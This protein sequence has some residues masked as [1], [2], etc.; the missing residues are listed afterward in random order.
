M[1]S[2]ELEE[3]LARYFDGDLDDAAAARLGA[4]LDADPKTLD[5]FH[6]LAAI[7]GLLRAR[8]ADRDALVTRVTASVRDERRRRLTLRVMET[9]HHRA[10]RNRPSHAI[11]IAA[12]AA[13][14][15]A[16][17]GL[18]VAVRPPDRPRPTVRYEKPPEIP[19]EPPPAPE[20]VRA[21]SR[22]EVPPPPPPPLER[23]VPPVP[24]AQ[25]P[26]PVRFHAP[27]HRRTAG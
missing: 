6:G 13:A 21:P 11:W 23:S 22:E 12:A 19:A 3:L 5:R 8:E 20:A 16:L 27:R 9:L 1:G 18:A 15:L 24:P 2:A 4:L 25:P 26:P 10:R 14:F 17:V 7:E